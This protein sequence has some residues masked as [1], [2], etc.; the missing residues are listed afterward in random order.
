MLPPAVVAQSCTP[1]DAHDLSHAS[2]DERLDD[3]DARLD[4]LPDFQAWGAATAK[5]AADGDDD[6]YLSDGDLLSPR[7]RALATEVGA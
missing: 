6:L 2:H 5:G 7:S 4:R 3:A 1:H